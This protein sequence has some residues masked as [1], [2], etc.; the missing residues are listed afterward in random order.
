[1]NMTMTIQKSICFV[2]KNSSTILTY[3]GGTGVIATALLSHRAAKKATEMQESEYYEGSSNLEKA[4]ELAKIYTPVIAVGTGTIACIIGA[5]VLNKRQQATMA[6]AYALSTNAFAKYRQKVIEKYGSEAEQEI[7]DD[8]IRDNIKKYPP[9]DHESEDDSVLCYEERY[10][11]TFYR[12]HEEVLSAEYETNRV[13]ILQGYATLNTFYTCMGLPTTPDGD[14][15]GWS[16]EGG[17][18][19]GYQW[20]DFEHRTTNMGDGLGCCVISFTFEPTWHGIAPF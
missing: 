9:L 20:I 7:R 1:M 15:I 11:K 17:D 5:N 18:E 10:G 12:T 14:M 16:V 6:S 19:Y 2:K 8:I 4:L 13:F 3:M